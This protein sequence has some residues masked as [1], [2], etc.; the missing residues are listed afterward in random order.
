[1]WKHFAC[2][3]SHEKDKCSTFYCD[4]RLYTSSH[5]SCRYECLDLLLCEVLKQDK[6]MAK[7]KEHVTTTPSSEMVLCSDSILKT[8]ESAV[9]GQLISPNFLTI[10]LSVY[11]CFVDRFFFNSKSALKSTADPSRQLQRMYRHKTVTYCRQTHLRAHSRIV[12]H[13]GMIAHAQKHDS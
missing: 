13:G 3:T 11:S 12:M 2:N 4:A 10:I 8:P 7:H 6:D 5:Y 9:R 1:M